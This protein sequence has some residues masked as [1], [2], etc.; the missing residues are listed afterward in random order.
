MRNY[1]AAEVVTMADKAAKEDYERHLPIH[2]DPDGTAWQIDK[3]PYCTQGA[4]YD[5][6]RGFEGKPA[7]S[8][9]GTLD[10]NFKYQRGA[11]MARL[12]ASLNQTES[13]PN[14]LT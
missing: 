11:A 13:K 1:T 9:E 8:W 12:L 3:N 4:R 6:Q 7:N 10:F 14:E 5:W 2:T